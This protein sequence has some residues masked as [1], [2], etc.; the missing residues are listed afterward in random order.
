MKLAII[1]PC[2][3]EE[4]TVGKV[5]KSV[6]KKILGISK[7]F[8][9]V[10]DDGSDDGSFKTAREAGADKIIRHKI[11]Q[12]LAKSFQNGLDLAI[13]LGA[14]VIVN[15]DADGQYN[16][17]QIPFLIAPIISGKAD[18][19]IGDRQ[20]SKLTFMPWGNKYGNIIGSFVLRALTKTKVKDVSSGFRAFSREAALHINIQSGNTYTHETIIQAAFDKLAIENVPIDFYPRKYGHSKLI[21]GI[22]LHIKNSILMITRIVLMYKP[23]KTLFYIGAGIMFFGI[24][25]G[26]RFLYFYFHSA[27]EGKIQSLILSSI[28]ISIGFFV[29]I[30]GLIGDLIAKNRKLNEKT[31][32]LLKK[33]E[34]K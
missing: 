16:Q 11:K 25:I 17:N 24:L 6:P 19:V 31:L 26:L 5:I 4:Q 21:S 15:T 28:L 32:Y 14:D 20:I 23:L 13:N 33:N 22:F 30:L 29:V 7:I 18:M 1:I 12:G 8:I 27:G 3:N 9:I 10:I 2:H 34:Q